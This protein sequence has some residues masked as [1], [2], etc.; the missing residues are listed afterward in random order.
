MLSYTTPVSLVMHLFVCV[1][2]R[3]SMP[4]HVYVCLYMF[5]HLYVFMR[6]CV[7]VCILVCMSDC[8]CMYVVICEHTSSCLLT[9]S[10]MIAFCVRRMRDCQLIHLLV[11]QVRLR[12][13]RRRTSATCKCKSPPQTCPPACASTHARQA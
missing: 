6:V 10:P 13:Q 11:S 4:M 12:A 1:C 8:T 2:V 7:Y 9:F 3:V 5:M